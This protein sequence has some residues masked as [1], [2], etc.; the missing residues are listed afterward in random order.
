MKYRSNLKNKCQNNIKNKSKFYE[1]LIENTVDIIFI[2][3]INYNF[4]YVNNAFSEILG[5]S[6]NELYESN[7][8]DFVHPKDL[9]RFKKIMQNI[10]DGNSYNNIEYRFRKKSNEYLFLSTNAKPYVDEN[11]KIIGILGI[12]RDISKTKQVELKL[13]ERA[14]QQ[15][16]VAEFGQ[17]AL[18]EKNLY[19]LFNLAV[20]ILV[21]TLDIDLAKILELSPDGEKLKLVAGVGWRAGYVGHETVDAYE[22]SQ[23]GYTL[24]N[25]KPVIVED[26][27]TETRF[28]G[29]KLLLDHNV[30]SGMSVIIQGING[31]YGILGAHCKNYRVFS[32][33]DINFLQSIANILASVLVQKKIETEL[34]K[35][36]ENLRKEF[37]IS[38]NTLREKE[39]LLKEIQHRVKNNLQIILSLIA[40]SKRNI[41]DEKA[42]QILNDFQVRIKSMA[43]IHEILYQSENFNSVDLSVYLKK[44]AEN[45]FRSYQTQ[46]KKIKLDVS[47]Q[48]IIL[49]LSRS[50]NCGLILNELLT[51]ALKYAFIN[52]DNGIL[53]IKVFKS[54]ESIIH[55]EVKDN[56]V[57]NI[58]QEE[59][60]NSDTLGFKLVRALTKQLEAN[61]IFDSTNGIFI[62]ISFKDKK[63]KD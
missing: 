8:C 60:E 37:E 39:V 35:S 62:K 42:K 4:L 18:I 44:L 52:M 5:Y 22:K 6:K 10:L 51:N 34:M 59:F 38:K 13:K 53:S 24:M 49:D 12:A 19:K 45:I 29:P 57:G 43:L 1:T 17:K 54:N 9:D 46:I 36:E 50:I 7:S 15:A 26:L 23:A 3:D 20:K 32:D 48:S 27:R 61:L 2:D 63:N 55:L 11:N 25:T 14:R 16:I 30:I 28:Q 41:S 31:P 47:I 40:L 33:D 58:T 56:G 21:S